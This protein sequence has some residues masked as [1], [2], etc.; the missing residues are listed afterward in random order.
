MKR[1][2]KDIWKRE[3][4]LMPEWDRTSCM[5]WQRS[6]ERIAVI[7]KLLQIFRSDTDDDASAANAVDVKKSG[8]MQLYITG[9]LGKNKGKCCGNMSNAVKSCQIM[10]KLAIRSILKL[11]LVRYYI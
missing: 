3:N 10:A 7:G 6:W 4:M 9:I 2:K 8:H 1:R 11:Y 5:R